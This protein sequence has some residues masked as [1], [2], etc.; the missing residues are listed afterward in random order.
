MVNEM[1]MRNRREM[2]NICRQTSVRSYVPVMSL[3]S[4]AMLASI[5]RADREEKRSNELGRKGRRKEG[6]K[7]ERKK[8]RE[9]KEGRKE[10]REGGRKEKRKREEGRKELGR[11]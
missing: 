1:L 5:S 7:E 10:G 4:K 6:R 11:N 8:G 2:L 3:S 9:R